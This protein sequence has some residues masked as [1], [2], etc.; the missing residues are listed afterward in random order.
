MK[1]VYIDDLLWDDEN[2][3]KIAAHQLTIN[4]VYQALVLDTDR[5][6]AW[7]ED[8]EHGRRLIAIGTCE[9]DNKRI[10]AYL[11]PVNEAEGI[12]RP[13]TAWRLEK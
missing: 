9:F 11:D 10:I 5:E 6:A 1:T 3:T 2:M 8:D 7:V 4:E 13:R 12:W